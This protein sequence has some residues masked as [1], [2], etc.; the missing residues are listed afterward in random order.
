MP[1]A[2]QQRCHARDGNVGQFS[3]LDLVQPAAVDTAAGHHRVRA[4]RLQ[5]Q[6]HPPGTLRVAADEPIE[7]ITRVEHQVAIGR[8]GLR[9]I[10]DESLHATD[11]AAACNVRAQEKRRRSHLLQVPRCAP[12]AQVARGNPG[13]ATLEVVPELRVILADLM[14]PQPTVQQP[15]RP[16]QLRLAG[17]IREH[18][19]QRQMSRARKNR[20]QAVPRNPAVPACSSVM[21]KNRFAPVAIPR[22][23]RKSLPASPIDAGGRRPRACRKAAP[24][25]RALQAAVRYPRPRRRA[26][27]VPP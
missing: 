4:D 24:F 11:L 2:P 18:F 8:D 14:L 15:Q 6:P 20:P 10:E 25:G 16:R 1:V 7:R 26:P 3:G 27:S 22:C 19:I 17:L 9:V 5:G 23:T 12:G 21:M 13:P